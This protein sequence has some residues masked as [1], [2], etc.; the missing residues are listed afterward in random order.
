M[1][2]SA[3]VGRFVAKHDGIEDDLG[4]KEPRG[5]LQSLATRAAL[6]AAP[7][8]RLVLHSPPNHASWMTQMAMG[9]SLVVRT[10]LKRARCTSV[11]DLE[12]RILACIA[13]CNATM[14]QPFTWTYGR[15]PLSVSRNRYFRQAVLVQPGG[16][17]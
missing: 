3:S 6:R 14:A 1:P 13:S 8:Q 12:A 15:K 16:S 4:H 2:Q 11:A 17:K 7:T 10:L 9:F 5:L